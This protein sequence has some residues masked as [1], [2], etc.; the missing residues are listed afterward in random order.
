MLTAVQREHKNRI[1]NDWLPRY[2]GTSMGGFGRYILL[3][4][5]SH[6]LNIFAKTMA[7]EIK[8]QDRPM[9][10][11]TV[12]LERRKTPTFRRNVCPVSEGV[13]VAND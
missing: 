5:F 3:T 6:Y 9:Q 2:T 7:V 4:N 8:G 10:S 12:Y 13:S 1:A 11:A